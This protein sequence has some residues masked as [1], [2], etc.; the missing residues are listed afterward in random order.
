MLDTY[1]NVLDTVR[2]LEDSDFHNVLFMSL[3]SVISM[4]SLMMIVAEPEP[5]GPYY[6]D[7]IRT[8]TVSLL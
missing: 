5:P 4:M 8:G 2:I 1:S 6:F 3:I 7:R